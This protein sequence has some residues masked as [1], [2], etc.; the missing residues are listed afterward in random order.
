MPIIRSKHLARAR[1]E[2][3]MADLWASHIERIVHNKLADL[4]S[5]AGHARSGGHVADGQAN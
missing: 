1:L 5:A 3:G 4:H 2:R